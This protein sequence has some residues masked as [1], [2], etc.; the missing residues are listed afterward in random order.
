[1]SG[2]T[3]DSS[4]DRPAGMD[5]FLGDPLGFRPLASRLRPPSSQLT[6]VRRDELLSA[7][8]QDPQAI[9]LLSAPAGCGKSM[10]LAQWLEALVSPRDDA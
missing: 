3:I 9:V 8:L 5:E 2:T 1:M 6:L 10:V 4:Q 7:L